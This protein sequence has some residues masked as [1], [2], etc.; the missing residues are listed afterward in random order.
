MNF[1]ILAQMYIPNIMIF[2]LCVG[3]IL[4][5]W[6]KDVDNKFIPSVLAIIGAATACIS[7]QSI[8]LDLVTSGM[9]TGLASTGLHQMFKQ[10]IENEGEK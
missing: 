5:H 7:E 6:I 9:L 2:C 1:D 3:Y 8:S 4:K 10:I